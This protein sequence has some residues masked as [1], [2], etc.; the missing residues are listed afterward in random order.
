MNPATSDQKEPDAAEVARARQQYQRINGRRRAIIW[1]VL[2][3]FIAGAGCMGFGAR[4]LQERP[5]TS[6]ILMLVGCAAC[7]LGGAAVIYW[8]KSHYTDDI[9]LRS[10]MLEPLLERLHMS[11]DTKERHLILE[12]LVPALNDAARRGNEPVSTADLRRIEYIVFPYL[13]TSEPPRRL[14][15][16][17]I[18]AYAKS[19][20]RQS[21]I[22]LRTVAKSTSKRLPD[23]AEAARRG[24]GELEERLA[25]SADGRDLLRPSGRNA[26]LLLPAAGVHADAGA[27]LRPAGDAD[28]ADG[29]AEHVRDGEA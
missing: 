21:L 11:F 10:E 7:V 24:A 8:P 23:V 25:R 17:A 1:S 20:D 22:L 29:S 19:G 6:L 14:L 9:P 16:A 26:D 13:H 3:L 12:M 18:E 4:S 2:L 15:L 28:T 27:L 5:I